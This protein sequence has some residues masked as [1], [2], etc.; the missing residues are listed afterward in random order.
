MQQLLEQKQEIL[1]NPKLNEELL[2]MA[3]QFYPNAGS[4]YIQNARLD[5]AHIFPF[6]ETAKVTPNS[7]FLIEGGN[8]KY[9]Y[10]SPSGVN[11]KLQTFIEGRMRNAILNLEDP[12]KMAA[13]EANLMKADELLKKLKL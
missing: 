4:Q 13:A 10:L 1:Q 7:S 11:R 9:L 5:L 8:P 3:K 6:T 12:T 2:M